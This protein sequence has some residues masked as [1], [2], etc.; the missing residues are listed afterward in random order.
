MPIAWAA[1]GAVL[2]CGGGAVTAALATQSE[3]AGVQ[4]ATLCA[5]PAGFG[6]AG[7]LAAVVTHFVVRRGRARVAVPFGCGCLGAVG[8]VGATLFFFAAVFPAL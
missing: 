3:S 2:V 8:A 6:I 5:G 7:A 4:A 1:V